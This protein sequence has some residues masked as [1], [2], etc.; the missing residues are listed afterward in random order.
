MKEEKK[1]SV[2]IN[3]LPIIPI[4]IIAV[5]IL[6]FI[7]TYTGAL[8]G[9]YY[10]DTFTP[11]TGTVIFSAIVLGVGILFL[12]M[13]VSCNITVTNIRVYGK[14]FFKRVD[15]P[16]DS[17]SAV[18][19]IDIIQGI[20]VASSSGRIAFFYIKNYK[21]IHSEISQLILNRHENNRE[22]ALNM[23]EPTEKTEEIRNYKKLLDD[24]IITQ[25]EYDKKKK[26]LLNL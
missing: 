2:S 17:I 6:L 21:E 13:A 16:V 18:G 25:E 5:G 7:L 22:Q 9:S 19:M 12:L 10:R 23:S 26:Q 3:G 8:G 20:S 4:I 14:A 1:I 11:F 15:I 24:G